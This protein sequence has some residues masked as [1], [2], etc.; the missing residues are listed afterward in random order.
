MYRF[1][2]ISKTCWSYPLKTSVLNVGVGGPSIPCIHIP[3]LL[4]SKRAYEEGYYY[5]VTF[6]LYEYPLLN[7]T[8]RETRT[9]TDHCP[10]GLKPN[11]STNSTTRALTPLMNSILIIFILQSDNF[12]VVLIH[13]LTPLSSLP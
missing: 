13:C 7:S 6:K 12:H 3:L 9:L 10:F 11:V 4:L 8:R 2:S 5:G 1:I